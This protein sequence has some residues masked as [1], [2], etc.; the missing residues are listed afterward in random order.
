M[1][2]EPVL[3]YSQHMPRMPHLILIS[4]SSGNSQLHPVKIAPAE[5]QEQALA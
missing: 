5:H 2:H 1:L 4:P 3:P